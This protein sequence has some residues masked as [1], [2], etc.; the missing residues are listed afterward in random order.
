MQLNAD[1]FSL[2]INQQQLAGKVYFTD[3]A[4]DIFVDDYHYHLPIWDPS[5]SYSR[6]EATAGHLQA[7]MPGTVV[8]VMTELGKTVVRGDSLIVIEAMKMEHTIYAPAAGTVE[9]I[10]YQVGEQVTEGAQLIA[11]KLKDDHNVTTHAHQDS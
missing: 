9:A 2:L 5:K 8:A 10:H 7:P 11:L 6:Q 3:N 1:N 4:C